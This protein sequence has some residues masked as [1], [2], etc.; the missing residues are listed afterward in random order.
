MRRFRF[1]LLGF[2]SFIVS[3]LVSLVTPGSWV[4]R[5]IATTMCGVM[6]ACSPGAVANFLQ[7]GDR[8][9]AA[10]VPV[11]VGQ[12]SSEF[13]DDL[14]A[15]PLQG[16]GQSTPSQTQKIE[17]NGIRSDFNEPDIQS[18]DLP[19]INNPSK[20]NNDGQGKLSAI[21]KTISFGPPEIKSNSSD[22]FEVSQSSPEGCSHTSLFR[23]TSDGGAYQESIRF[24]SPGIDICGT[25]SFL[26]KLEARGNKIELTQDAL[27]G[28]LL[29]ELEQKEIQVLYRSTEGLKKIGVLPVIDNSG[30][31]TYEPRSKYLTDNHQTLNQPLCSDKY[32]KRCKLLDDSKKIFDILSGSILIGS[33]I[34]SLGTFLGMAGFAGAAVAAAPALAAIGAASA[35]IGLGYW[36][37]QGGMPPLPIPGATYKTV[38]IGFA[39]ARSTINMIKAGNQFLFD[40]ASKVTEVTP[41]DRGLNKGLETLN[42]GLAGMRKDLGIDW[43]D[44]QEIK[45]KLK[46]V[47]R[48][49]RKVDGSRTRQGR[50]Y[51][52]PHIITF[53]GYS[54]DFQTIGEFTLVKSNEEGFEVQVRQSAV[55]GTASQVS[56]NTGAAMK[57]GNQR[58][59][60]YAKDFPDSDTSTPV[61]IDGKPVNIN[62][63]FPLDGGSIT[64]TNGVY[65]V[66]WD[67]GEQ[68][69]INSFS[70]GGMQLLNVAPSVPE[71][72]GR[73]T[74][75]LGDLD[76]NPNNDL[77]TRSGKVIPTKSGSTYGTLKNVISSVVSIPLP[78]SQLE[79]AFFDQLYKDFGDS[80]RISQNESLF[81]Y[82]PGK[83]TETFTKRG[84]PNTYLRLASFIAP[85]LKHAEAIC[86]K[87]NVGADMMDGCI[88][89]VANTGEAGFAQVAAN[90]VVGK[91]KQRAEQEIRKRIPLPFSLPF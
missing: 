78:I 68:V 66:N 83:S 1:L 58:V 3:F 71:E 64:G 88:F 89:D 81:D 59:A 22:Y 25:E 19:Q 84:F 29:F 80:W 27:K 36:I 24:Q 72:A 63:E 39:A 77:R 11:L 65:T 2:S 47:N 90:M 40:V 13:D 67:S 51:G 15:S 45:D 14:S 85:Q 87:A 86:Q 57:V 75:I 50:S 82:A 4:N 9:F 37:L 61:R 23:R 5:A 48:P 54:Y 35:V 21:P 76:G 74:G 7:G 42:L 56:L 79:T 26:V 18:N 53:D 62:G 17:P 46:S 16:P 33:T 44:S 43:C 31:Q 12:R 52:D 10:D 60:F 55:P 41:K 73:Y 8:A 49:P 30:K 91:V 69:T 34:L 32:K 20:L 6:G 28:S 38:G 70:T